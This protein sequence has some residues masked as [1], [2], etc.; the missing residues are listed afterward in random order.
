MNIGNRK[1]LTMALLVGSGIFVGC[2]GSDVSIVQESRMKGWPDYTI[3]QMLDKRKACS[4]TDWKSFKDDRDRVIVEYTCVHG[5]GTQYVQKLNEREIEEEQ[6]EPDRMAR[7]LAGYLDG[8]KEAVDKYRNMLQEHV[9]R[10][11]QS[12]QISEIEGNLNYAEK[13]Y[14]KMKQDHENSALE[15]QEPHVKRVALL[16]RRAAN[17]EETNEVFQWVIQEKSPVFLTSQIKVKFSDAAYSWPIDMKT[18]FDIAAA[19]SMEMTA[20]YESALANLTKKYD[21]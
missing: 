2:T 12:W 11:A 8:K 4:K 6:N 19:N 10:G 3:G 16:E 14:L 21:K 1:Y 5:P 7:A 17:F 9:E 15:G 18:M 20:G 13:E